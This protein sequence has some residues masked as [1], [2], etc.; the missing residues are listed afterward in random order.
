M[1]EVFSLRDMPTYKKRKG[2]DNLLLD[3]VI[4][5]VLFALIAEES[6][7]VFDVVLLFQTF[8]GK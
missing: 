5:D 2:V 4:V 3:P 1:S 6:D 8:S 7:D